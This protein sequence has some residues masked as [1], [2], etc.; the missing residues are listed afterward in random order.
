[1]PIWYISFFKM[2]KKII[3]HYEFRFLAGFW[4]KNW[5]NYLLGKIFIWMPGTIF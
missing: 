1:M 3:K 4:Y 2:Q 5:F